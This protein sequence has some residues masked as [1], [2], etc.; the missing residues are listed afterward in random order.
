MAISKYQI[1]IKGISIIEILIVI[2]IIGITLTS[3]L[4]VAAFS[5]RVSTLIKEAT[6]AN[7]LTQETIE[8]VR[9]FRDGTTWNTDG[10]GTL[11]VGT[12]HPHYPK[13]DTTVDPPK[14]T[15]P[16]GTETINGFTRKVIFTDVMRD[17]DDNIVETGGINDP[18]TKKATATVSW[19]DK[20]VEIVTYFT[21]WK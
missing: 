21:D 9:N 19:K 10:L 13:L 1:S 15:L 11:S 4:G 17:V 16:E 14:W 18:N 3:L 6:R 20:K 8:A 12:D 2:T 5:L 7:T